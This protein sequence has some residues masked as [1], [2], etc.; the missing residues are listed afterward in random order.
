MMRFGMILSIV[1]LTWLTPAV[2]A[3]G[4]DKPAVPKDCTCAE[5]RKAGMGWCK[6]CRQGLALGIRF[7]SQPVYR[8][9]AGEP[10]MKERIKKCAGCIKAARQQGTCE[11]C[12]L[13]F[14]G[15]RVYRSVYAATLA[16]GKVIGAKN[17][18]CKTCAGSIR[19]GR[20]GYCKDCDGGIVAGVFFKGE[21]TFAKAVR[22]FKLA[23]IANDMA[24]TCEGCAVAMLT[25]G[26]CATCHA[27]YSDGKRVEAKSQP[28]LP[29]AP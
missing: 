24:A 13:T 7:K 3:G 27:K 17:A 16:R 12:R 2:W 19:E 23:Q 8:L 20:G 11:E 14:A 25:D 26:E 5:A 1:A 18:K 29:G 15:K 9:L 28:A 21:E 10:A 6:A 22:A 4:D